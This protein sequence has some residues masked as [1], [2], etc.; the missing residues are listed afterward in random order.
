MV[1]R[2]QKD[3]SPHHALRVNCRQGRGYVSTC[4]RDV[5]DHSGSVELVVTT[6][7]AAH[8]K[9]FTKPPPPWPP[10]EPCSRM[11]FDA[12]DFETSFLPARNLSKLRYNKYA[13]ITA[14]ALRSALKEE[15]RVVAEKRGVTSVRFQKWEGGVGGPQVRFEPSIIACKQLTRSN[16][17]SSTRLLRRNRFESRLS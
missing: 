14:R 13:Q 9:L 16:R 5:T 2:R 7:H 1:V 8:S 3:P 6:V 11:L 15:E 10:G 17:L 12:E 4:T